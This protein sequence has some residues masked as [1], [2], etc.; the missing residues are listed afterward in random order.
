MTEQESKAGVSLYVGLYAVDGIDF[1]DM[2]EAANKLQAKVCE[3][4]GARDIGGGTAFPEGG[5]FE[6]DLDFEVDS[7]AHATEVVSSVT[8]LVV[9]SEEFKSHAKFSIVTEADRMETLPR[10]AGEDA[11]PME[12]A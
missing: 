10:L 5:G 7:L 6:R 11:P 1:D 4:T 2:F 8:R 12:L 3:E 9:E